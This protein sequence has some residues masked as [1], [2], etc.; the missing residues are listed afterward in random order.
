MRARLGARIGVA[1][2]ALFLTA[3]GSPLEPNT[4]ILKSWLSTFNSGDSEGLETFQQR[5]LGDSDIRFARDSREESGGFDLIRIEADDP[6]KLTAL[7]RERN[8]PSTWRLTIARED[9]N[10]PKLKT[11]RYEALPV[12]QSEALA[13]LTGFADRLAAADE[14]SGVV[15]IS[16]HGQ[17]LLARAWGLADREHRTPVRLDTPFLFASQGKMFTAVAVFQLVEKGRVSLDDPIGKYLTDYPNAEIARKVTVR[18]LL[19]H[20]GGTGDMGVLEPGDA[21]N[22]ARVHSIDDIIKLNGSR[23]PAF[24]PGTRVEYSNYGYV[25]LGALVQRVTGEAYYDY[26]ERHIFRV[27]GMAHTSYPRRENMRRVAVGYT[28]DDGKPLHPSTDWLPWRGTPAGGGVSTAEDMLCF[29]AALNAGKLISPEMLAIA[30]TRQPHAHGFAY[31]FISSA[32]D[33]FPYWGHGGGAPGNSL[34]LDYYP[35]TDTTFVCM[36]NR[37]PIVCDRLAFNYLFRAPRTP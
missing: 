29:A 12:S 17:S 9:V 21:D 2:G 23:G 36:S 10:A 20:Q 19:G 30:T 14:F 11:L 25:L 37:D 16:Q 28:S 24:E 18:E 1:L 15:A 13:A 33:G 26:V 32:V 4:E 6:L 35:V 3:A 31:G 27:A 34:V 7:L 5:Y 22:R 8:F